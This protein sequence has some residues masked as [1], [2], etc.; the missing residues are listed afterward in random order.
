[1]IRGLWLWDHP[2]ALIYAFEHAFALAAAVVHGFMPYMKRH[3]WT[4][5]GS[6]KWFMNF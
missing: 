3:G 4:M 2:S 1:V 6:I 5:Y